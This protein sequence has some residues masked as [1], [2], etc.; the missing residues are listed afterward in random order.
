MTLAPDDVLGRYHLLA[1]CGGDDRAGLQFWHARDVT[2]GRDVALTVLPDHPALARHVQVGERYAATV[3]HPALAPVT[4]MDGH[5]IAAEWAP[6]VDVG[7][8]VLGAHLPVA[9]VV[10]LLRPLVDAVEAAHHAGVPAGIDSPGRV[11]IAEHGGALVA[12]R[13]TA[14]DVTTRDDVR[15]LGAITYLLLT[16]CWP[17]ADRGGHLVD[18]T[19]LRPDLPRDLATVAALSLDP[20]LGPDIRTCGPLLRALD[21]ALVPQAAPEP[22]PPPAPEPV[23]QRR[24]RRR[25]FAVAAATLV[26]A[27]VVVFGIQFAGSFGVA[28]PSAAAPSTSRPPAPTTTT[29]TPPPTTTT[30][31]PP[32]PRPVTP[33]SVREFVV[34]GSEDNPGTLF[35]A[36]D[37]DPR[38]VWKTDEYRQQFPLFSPGIGILAGFGQPVALSSVTITSPSPGTVVQLRSAQAPDVSLDDTALLATATLRDGATTIPVAHRAAPYLLVWIVRLDGTGSGFQSQ[39]AD[40]TAQPAG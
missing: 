20:S 1:P 7:D 34:S 36:A 9:T 28:S 30:T 40:I 38:T 10:R 27:L 8:G 11:R 16:G 2:D 18:P 3:T 19:V 15:A 6:S 21:Q 31:T 25:Q 29:T 23:A 4:D 5:V 24:P 22:P 32:A 13:G 33:A 14:P 39:V 17:V 35:R 12:F 37:G 26:A